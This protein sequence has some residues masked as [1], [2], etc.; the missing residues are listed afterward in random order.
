MSGHEK[1]QDKSNDLGRA[2]KHRVRTA[3]FCLPS[4]CWDLRERTRME[5]EV[6]SSFL[7]P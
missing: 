3:V 5:L 1:N 4:Y 2:S 6:I 7:Q